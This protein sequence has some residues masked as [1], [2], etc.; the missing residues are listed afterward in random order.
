MTQAC[1]YG[2]HS[3]IRWGELDGAVEV[4]VGQ[5]PAA[6]IVC[7]LY[8]LYKIV[9][10]LQM[11]SNSLTC[12]ALM[13]LDEDRNPVSA[14][15]NQLVHMIPSSRSTEVIKV[16]TSWLELGKT[17]TSKNRGS[18]SRSEERSSKR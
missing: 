3:L 6:P 13:E 9:S 10:V 2:L 18:L 4:R 14:E 5:W 11:S 12:L 1:N 15:G 17:E 16:A 8:L 7:I